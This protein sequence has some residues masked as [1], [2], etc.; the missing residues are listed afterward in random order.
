[1]IVLLFAKS[2]RKLVGFGMLLVVL[3]IDVVRE[4]VI[5]G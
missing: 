5:V 4:G 2:L 1:M 3:M